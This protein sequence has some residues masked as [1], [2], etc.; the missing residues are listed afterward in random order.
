MISSE[1][2]E[3]FLE[4]RELLHEQFK[5]LVEKSKECPV[6]LLPAL[7]AQMIAIHSVLNTLNF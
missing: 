5:L 2:S 1:D 7:C 4:E 3:H 6:E